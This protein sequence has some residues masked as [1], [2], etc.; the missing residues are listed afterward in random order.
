MRERFAFALSGLSD[1]QRDI[2]ETAIKEEQYIVGPDETPP[3]AFAA[4]ADQF[5]DHE[6]V[7]G[8]EEAGEGDLSGTYLVQY[9][10]EVYW[11]IL[12]VSGDAL[13]TETLD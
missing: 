9:D 2:V 1:P 6:Q 4:L 8:L 10:G 7:H 5:R 13:G 11:T 3:S 12:V